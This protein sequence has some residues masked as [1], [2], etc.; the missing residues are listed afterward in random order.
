MQKANKGSFPHHLREERLH[1]HWSQKEIA[2][3]LGTTT[4]NVSRWELGQT[5]PGLY[6]RTKLCEIF[7]KTPQELGLVGEEQQISSSTPD[8]LSTQSHELPLWNVPYQRN[9]FFTGREAILE[10]LHEILH[11]KRTTT[12]TQSCALS[13]LGGI[14]KTQMAIEYAHRHILDY[15]AIFWVGAETPE[16][17]VSSFVS[18]AHVLN[19]PEKETP[20]QHRVVAAVTR[21]LNSHSEWLLIFDNVEDLEMVKRFLPTAPHGYLLFTTRIQAL[22]TM[23]HRLEIKSMTSQDGIQFLLQRARLID[24]ERTMQQLSA[25]EHATARAIVEAMDGL[26]LALDQAGA[27]IDET[28]CGLADFLALFQAHPIYLLNE[29]LA[30]LDHPLSVV[31]TFTLAFE[32]VERADPVA[33]DLLRFCAFLYPDAIP[34]ECFTQSKPIPGASLQPVP[35]NQIRFNKAI[36]SLQTSSLLQRNAETKTLTIHRLVQAVLKERMDERERTKWAVQVIRMIYHIFPTPAFETWPQC[37][38]F[39]PHALESVKHE[40]LSEQEDAIATELSTVLVK[41]GQYLTQRAQYIEAERLLQRALHIR[42]AVLGPEHPEVAVPLNALGIVYNI[43]NRYVDAEK[44]LQRALSIREVTLG[45]GHPDLAEALADLAVSTLYQG[46]YREAEHFYQRAVEIWDEALGP[47]H[48]KIAVIL[49]SLASIYGRQERY[50]EADALLQRAFQ[51]QEQVLTDDHPELVISL[52]N[53][54]LLYSIQGKYAQAEPLFQRAVRIRE[55]ASGPD[56]PVVAIPLT[57]LASVYTKQAKWM[58]AEL[59][60]QRALRIWEQA[61]GPE[62]PDIAYPLQGLAELY[63]EQGNYEQAEPLYQRTL[64]I[65]E[66]TLGASHPGVAETLNGL[67]VLY[68][69]HKNYDKAEPI[70]RRALQIREQTLGTAHSEVAE[71]QFAL[72]YLALALGDT[73]TAQQYYQQALAIWQKTLKL[74]H[75]QVSRWIERYAQL[76]DKTH[77]E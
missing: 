54:A 5:T 64:H 7:G 47:D 17:L 60:Y 59:L 1:R 14:G 65:R 67:G 37:E 49:G 77:K 62:H 51:I 6:F 58:E 18:I 11:Q 15:S 38:R 44:L 36:A 33:A 19:L 43:Q 13:G 70:L 63:R 76:E 53:L 61:M 52:N 74:D 16:S 32:Q 55:K 30:Y 2:D 41:T 21:W 23:A 46:K 50:E 31:K 72:A 24:H 10:R 20:E 69:A 57:N 68:L 12:R 45:P 25:G 26:P 3:R 71:S 28:Q 27:Y 73:I 22:G 9:P 56:H 4:N 39:L 29:R 8:M 42:E 40:V 75:P 48:P 35:G 34:E 66:Q